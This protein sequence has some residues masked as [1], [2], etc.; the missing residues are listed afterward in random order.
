[1]LATLPTWPVQTACLSKGPL[2]CSVSAEAFCYDTYNTIAKHNSEY[3]KTLDCIVQPTVCHML[4]VEA[5]KKLA[6]ERKAAVAAG[7]AALAAFEA[8]MAADE[9]RRCVGCVCWAG[10][11]Q[12]PGSWACHP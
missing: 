2:G 6:E 11:P 9:E 5:E 4:Q 7:T 3:P 10:G 8:K 1:M 12:G